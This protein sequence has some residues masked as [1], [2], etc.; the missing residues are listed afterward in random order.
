MQGCVRSERCTSWGRKYRY[1]HSFKTKNHQPTYS[2]F[3]E[4]RCWLL[5][6]ALPGPATIHSLLFL[7]EFQKTPNR[8][9]YVMKFIIVCCRSIWRQRPAAEKGAQRRETESVGW[10]GASPWPTGQPQGSPVVTGTKSDC[11][12]PSVAIALAKATK[13]GLPHLLL[14]GHGVQLPPPYPPVQE[15]HAGVVRV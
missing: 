5:T 2:Q 11:E 13:V 10:C 7:I 4:S 6:A 12:A 8:A 15:E 3:L 1:Y 14:V 9:K